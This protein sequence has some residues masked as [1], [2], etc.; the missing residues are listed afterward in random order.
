MA[1]TGVGERL[2]RL[3]LASH[4]G[5]LG[6]GMG[7]RSE[8]L[9][10]M[11][12]EFRDTVGILLLSKSV[13]LFLDCFF[14]STLLTDSHDGASVIFIIV[15]QLWPMDSRSRKKLSSIAVVIGRESLPLLELKSDEG[16]LP[17]LE[18]D[19]DEGSRP[20]LELENG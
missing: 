15:P 9:P 20:L 3:L 19:C 11:G 5:T 13:L 14:V 1:V 16:S 7:G 8:M 18:L 6:S 12:V 2:D 17:L 10:L 4:E